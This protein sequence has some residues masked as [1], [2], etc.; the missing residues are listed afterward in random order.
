MSPSIYEAGILLPPLVGGIRQSLVFWYS[1][2]LSMQTP[3]FKAKNLGNAK[4][5]VLTP[6]LETSSR[7]LAWIAIKSGRG[8]WLAA[9]AL[10]LQ[11]MLSL[12]VTNLR[13]QQVLSGSLRLGVVGKIVAIMDKEM[14][15]AAAEWLPLVTNPSLSLGSRHP[16]QPLPVP[17]SRFPTQSLVLLVIQ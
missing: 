11:E 15:M 9:Q 13:F 4:C 7:L 1:R 8:L 10:S 5:R 14:A 6:E 12:L 17:W 2:P 16:M 3:E